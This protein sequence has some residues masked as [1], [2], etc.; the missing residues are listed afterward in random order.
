MLGGEI[1][2][3]S[4]V[5]GL[6]LKFCANTLGFRCTF[7]NLACVYPL[8]NMHKIYNIFSFNKLNTKWGQWQ[9]KD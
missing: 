8:Q 2:T 6:D 1:G 3:G 4:F 7:W 5:A 9:V